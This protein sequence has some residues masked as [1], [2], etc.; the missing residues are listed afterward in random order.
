MVAT[1]LELLCVSLRAPKGI[2]VLCYVDQGIEVVKIHLRTYVNLQEP[3]SIQ[4]ASGIIS[5]FATYGTEEIAKK[6]SE[7]LKM[8]CSEWP[9]PHN[10]GI[11]VPRGQGCSFPA[12]DPRDYQY[13]RLLFIPGGC[14]VANQY[15]E[16]P[17]ASRARL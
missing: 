9:Q 12:I 13:R 6:A 11:I 7:N 10:H 3:L 2:A 5:I 1:S 17:L 15:L 16:R 4:E 14:W 8:L